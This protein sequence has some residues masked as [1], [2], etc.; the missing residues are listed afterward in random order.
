MASDDWFRGPEWDEDAQELFWK[1]F[2]R[3]RDQKHFYMRV[4]AQAIAADHPGEA[5]K[6][7]DEYIAANE[8]HI[9]GG[10]YSKSMIYLAQG[11]IDAAFASLEIAIGKNG[12]GMDASGVMEYAFLS[13]L[14]K[15]TANYERALG[16]LDVLDGIMQKQ[17]GRPFY[18]SFAGHAGSAFIFYDMGRKE[19][20]IEPAK[21]ALEMALEKDGPMPGHPAIG[22]VPQLP[23][24]MMDRLIV[25]ADIWDENT[26]GEKPEI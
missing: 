26:M 25:I 1:K 13:G 4:K 8:T 20:A 21:S 3:A 12:M 17:A 10:N 7:F 14:Y 5:L 6:L 2:S 15:R 19:E 16:F 11:E 24:E 18:R 9:S 23:K 22:A